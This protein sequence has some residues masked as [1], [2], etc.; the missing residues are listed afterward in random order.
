E[1]LWLCLSVDCLLGSIPLK[2]KEESL[3]VEE[4][5]TKQLYKDYAAFRIDLWQNM[6]KNRP[7]VDQLLLFKKTQKLLDRFLFIFF[8]EDSGLLPPN[9]ISRIVKRWNVLQDEDAYKPLYDIFNQ[10]FGYINTGRKGKTPQDDIFAYNGGLFFS[11]EVLDNIVIDDDVL[12][13]HVMKLTAYDFQS[14]IDVN[15][16][17][18]I[19]ENSLSEIENVIAK[20]EGKEVDKNKTKRKKEGIFYTPKYITKYIIDN[21]LGK[22]CE[23]KKTELGIVDEEYAKGRRN[24]KKETIKKL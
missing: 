6:V 13:P 7:E 11:D 8:A 5:V 23:E 4:N 21:T 14:E 12:Q 18:H 20:L 3:L 10:Y 17:G 24:R 16:L 15:I 1:L 22:L 19:F 2:V 9:S